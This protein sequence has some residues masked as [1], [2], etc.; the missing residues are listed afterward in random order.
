MNCAKFVI[1]VLLMLAA[2]NASK[3]T[4]RI[5]CDGP[6]VRGIIVAATRDHAN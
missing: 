3:A 5:S 4:V 2:I 6:S 1:V